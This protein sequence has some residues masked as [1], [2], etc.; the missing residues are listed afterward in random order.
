MLYVS[1]GSVTYFDHNSVY[2]QSQSPDSSHP[3]FPHRYPG[4]CSLR[5]CSLFALQIRS[6]L[7]VLDSTYEPYYTTF[8]FLSASIFNK[9][10]ER[11][12]FDLSYLVK[13]YF[14]SPAVIITP[15]SAKDL[16]GFSSEWLPAGLF[17]AEQ[18]T[19]HLC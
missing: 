13:F 19:E 3:R 14:N 4:V 15:V 16:F 18:T 1:S 11:A 5:L 17:S 6:S 9:I 12:V 7:S 10:K 2:M 8:V